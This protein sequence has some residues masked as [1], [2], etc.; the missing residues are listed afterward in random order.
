MAP[1][2]KVGGWVGGWVVSGG[3]PAAIDIPAFG[4]VISEDGCGCCI[5]FFVVVLLG[6]FS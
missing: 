4:V 6:F 3:K 2:T 5:F 1:P